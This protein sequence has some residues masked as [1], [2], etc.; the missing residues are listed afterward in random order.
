MHIAQNISL[1][2]FH[3]FGIPVQ[4]SYFTACN[5]VEQ[6]REALAFATQQKIPHLVLGGGSNILFTKNFGGL[7]LKNELAGK[8]RV[9]ETDRHVWLKAGAGENWHQLVLYCVQQGWGG[10]EN[11]ALIP[12]SAGAAPIQNIGAYGVE[13]KDIVEELEA[14][15]IEEQAMVRFSNAECRFGYRDSVFKQ[16]YKHRLIITSVTFKLDKQ[17]Q[18]NTRYQAL[19]AELEQAGVVNPGINDVCAAVIRIRSS[20]LP[21][22]AEI[23][24]AGSFFKNP[25]V[26]AAHF[27]QLQLQYPNIVGYPQANG[28]VKLAAGWLIETAG[29]KGVRRGDAGCHAKQALVLVNYGKATGSEIWQLSEDIVLSVEEKF[30]VR[31]EREVNV[32]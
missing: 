9:R 2:P 14:W 20:K 17:P 25:V 8:E 10:M 24:N 13:L 28:S 19:A 22:P 1:Q 30:G 7:V 29:W 31:L 12:G 4:S 3:T 15:H 21:N 23:G 5:T 6:F 18:I 11:L 16:E 26:E 27:A 32:L